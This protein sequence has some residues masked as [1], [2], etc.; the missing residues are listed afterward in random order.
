MARPISHPLFRNVS[1][2]E[3][4]QE[5]RLLEVGDCILRPCSRGYNSI[6]LSLKIYQGKNGSVYEHKEIMEGP[7]GSGQGAHLRL[8]LPL[9]IHIPG[10]KKLVFDDLDEVIALYVEKYMARI[11]SIVLH[12]KFREG[13]RSEIDELLNDEKQRNG[14]RMAV[15][16][17]GLEYNRP[18]FFYIASIWSENVHHE[19]FAVVPD[20]YYFRGHVYRSVDKMLEDFKKTPNIVSG[21]DTCNHIVCLICSRDC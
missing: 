10:N 13:Y 2:T 3:C 8:G 7:K 4:M 19:H 1:I 15:Y 6:I 5:L 11:R 21:L 14:Q 12:R 20:G 16:A 17:L 9:S 18:G